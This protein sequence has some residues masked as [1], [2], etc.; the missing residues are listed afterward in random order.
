MI[1]WL[2]WE[3]APKDGRNLLA[4]NEDNKKA[5]CI[6]RCDSH[7][8]DSTSGRV[9]GVRGFTHYAEINPPGRRAWLPNDRL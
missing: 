8:A 7:W 3:D 5:E 6:Y 4:W 2:P 1:N 9:C